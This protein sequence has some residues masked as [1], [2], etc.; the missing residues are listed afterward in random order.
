MA[1]LNDL[2]V[3]AAD[4]QNAYLTAPVPEKIW[5]KLGP[6]FGAGVRKVAIIVRALY[7][8]KSAGASFRNHHA[9]KYM[10]ELEYES[11]KAEAD[12]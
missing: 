4:I 3:K 9:D 1:A 10:Q 11:C 7:G 5:T 2:E 6:K 8:L 12:V